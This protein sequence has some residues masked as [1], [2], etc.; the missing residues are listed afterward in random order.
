MYRLIDLDV[1]D[2][3]L[4][5]KRVVIKNE[6]LYP[7][8]LGLDGF[9]EDGKAKFELKPDFVASKMLLKGILRGLP[10]GA[11]K[12]ALLGKTSENELILFRVLNFS[13]DVRSEIKS[14]TLNGL[15][16]HSYLIELVEENS[17]RSVSFKIL[18]RK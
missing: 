12:I 17:L 6:V 13:E 4:I 18:S 9:E 7:E 15:S 5:R 14:L 11:G 1:K 10:R 2:F 16:L 3:K 8:L